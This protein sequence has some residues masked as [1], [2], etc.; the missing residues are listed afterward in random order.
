MAALWRW[1]GGAGLG[2]LLALGLLGGRWEVAQEAPAVGARIRQVRSSQDLLPGRHADGKVG[3]WLLENERIRVLINDPS[4]PF[5]SL[6]TG[7]NILDAIPWGGRDDFHQLH[8]YFGDRYPRQALYAKVTPVQDGSQGGPAVLRAEGVDS[9]YAGLKVV[10]DYILEPGA[11]HVRIITRVRNEGDQD[12]GIFPLGDA[13]QWGHADSFAPGIGF[14]LMRTNPQVDWLGGLGEAAAYGYTVKQG[15]VTGPSGNLWS[16][17]IVVR[18][19][20]PPGAEASFERFFIV[21]PPDL[22]QVARVAYAL[23]GTAVGVVRGRLMEE[24]SQAKVEDATV[25]VFTPQGDLFLAAAGRGGTYEVPLPPGE[26]RLEASHPARA[27]RTGPVTLRLAA[28]QS[29]EHSFV[30]SLPSGFQ[31]RILDAQTGE[32]I[33]AKVTVLG[34]NGTP[35]PDFGPTFLASG[36]LNTALTH[37]GEIKQPLP[38]GEY[39]FI[40]SRGIEYELDRRRVRLEGGQNLF[41]TFSLLRSVDTKGYISADFH[42]HAAP[43][44]DS[45]VPLRDRVISNLAEG[46]EF[47]V[48]SDH[49]VVTDYAP[50][51]RQMG[52]GRWIKSCVGDEVTTRNPSIGHFNGFP[53]LRNPQHPYGGPI[54][55][56]GQTPAQIF[57]NIRLDPGIEVVQVNHPRTGTIGYF[58]L[59]R[60]NPKTGRA[61]D[62]TFSFAFDALEIL[63]GKELFY[64]EEVLQDWFTLLNRGYRYTATGNSDTHQVAGWEA[65]YPRNFVASPTDEPARIDENDVVKAVHAH[66]VVVTYGPFVQFWINGKPVG[67]E[68]VA[69]GGSLRLEVKVQ[70]PSWIEV[71]EIEVYANGRRWKTFPA[72]DPRGIVKFWRRWRT[73]LRHDTWFVVLARG[74]KSLAPVVPDYRH[75]DTGKPFPVTPVALTNPIWVDANGDGRFTLPR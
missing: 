32:P 49:N 51:V 23:R 10:T 47:I 13:L 45:A 63:N 6:P 12:L 17:T 44:F 27:N 18:P 38:P 70:A 21:T 69:R 20:L 34:Q 19:S 64:L 3:D 58:N 36:S 5:G 48:S 9:E 67:S 59:L 54:P 30:L 57:E 1:A 26:Y 11:E 71:D 60:L 68:V 61:E 35:D 73:T 65:G 43:S 24:G 66:Q 50:V 8:T 25:R 33:P 16:D 4:N 28:G 39:E 29:L 2:F 75:R 22:A 37:N 14:E 42:Q 52:V 41:L 53:L 62:P 55:F 56:M 31:A 72:A 74:R 7:G 40:A 46:V 15:P